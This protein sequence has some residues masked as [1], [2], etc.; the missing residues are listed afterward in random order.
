MTGKYYLIDEEEA[1]RVQAMWSTRGK[2]IVMND[3]N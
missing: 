3:N 2:I 1:K